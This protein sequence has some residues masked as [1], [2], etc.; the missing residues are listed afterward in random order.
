MPDHSLSEIAPDF[1]S[2]EAREERNCPRVIGILG[3]M[4]PL[5]TADLYTR[6]IRA[7]PATRDREHLHVIIA[8][9]PTVP[10]RTAALRGEGPDPLPALVAG[11]RRL[12]TAGAEIVAL[13]CNTAHAF[14]PALRKH[15]PLDYLDMIA[16]T[17]A[18]LAVD[19][20]RVRR[21]G[22]LATR[23]TIASGLYHR[24]LGQ[25]DVEAITLIDAAQERLVDRAIALVQGGDL[26]PE[27]GRLLAQGARRLALEGA[28]VVVAAC[29]EMPLVLDRASVPV[30]LIDPT[31]LLAEALVREA[32]WR[33]PCRR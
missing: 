30:P 6:I 28:E 17:A 4:G 27:P 11:A 22:L 13:V 3:G 12:Q 8:A 32:T 31:Q 18:R 10:D 25:Y 33:S 1:D 9:D 7:T 15:V 20:P 2:A 23:G 21:A 24:A 29:T 19:L 16:E 5:A 14:L 26:G